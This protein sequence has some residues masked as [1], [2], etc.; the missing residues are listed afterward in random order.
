M[1]APNHAE[2]ARHGISAWQGIRLVAERDILVQLRSRAFQ[3]GLAVTLLLVVGGIL[4][5]QLLGG[6][7]VGTP[8]VAATEATAPIAAA[9]GLEVAVTG[10][11]EDAV[12]AVESGEVDSA[13]LP[14][15]AITELTAYAS[16]GAPAVLPAGT[17]LFVLGKEQPDQDVATALAVFPPA[18]ALEQPT[19]NLALVYLL[20]VA[21]GVVFMFAAVTYGATIAQGVVEEK[22][23]RIVEILLATVEPRVLFAGKVI[24][25][26]IVA[27]GQVALIGAAA[28]L[29]LLATGQLVLV[30]L[31]GPPVAWFVVLFVVGFVLLAS[32]YAGVAATVSRQ[33]DVASATAPLMTVVM[34]PYLLSFFATGNPGL[35]RVLSYVPLSAPVSM[36]VRVYN[37]D[38]AWW[39]PALALALLVLTAAAAIWLGGRIYQNSVLRTG[40]RVKLTQALRA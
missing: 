5:L 40:S 2:A 16:D 13:V 21:F 26:S 8:K 39:E 25:G 19:V 37:G 4:L 32:L 22:Q 31:I 1:T 11:A 15:A 23:T 30:A 7:L 29:T 6:S 9:A 33:E 35:L 36:P 18:F 3:I 12:A 24:G 14:A 38:A 28:C 34:I 27:I 20:S 10:S 17:E